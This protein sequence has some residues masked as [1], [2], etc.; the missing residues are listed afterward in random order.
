MTT[1]TPQFSLV[2]SAE[3]RTQLLTILSQ[4]LRDT[5]VEEHRTDAPD[6][7][8]WVLRREQILED[9]V[10]RLKTP[11]PGPPTGSRGAT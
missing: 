6:Y 8:E 7:R 3:E 9:I 5:R 11:N 2:L 4:V 10:N 1:V